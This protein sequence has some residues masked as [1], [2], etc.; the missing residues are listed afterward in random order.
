MKGVAVARRMRVG[1]GATLEVG[2]GPAPVPVGAAARVAVAM[3]FRVAMVAASG[4]SVAA[5]PA[6]VDG[7]G[8]ASPESVVALQAT[9]ATRPTDASPPQSA[10]RQEIGLATGLDFPIGLFSL[11]L[12]V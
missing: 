9:A 7:G 8:A 5:T 2:V 10:R 11:P 3:G 1:V 6:I 12:I 4:D